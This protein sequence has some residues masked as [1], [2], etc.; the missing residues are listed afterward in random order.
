MSNLKA[1]L[2][3]NIVLV[4]FTL[5]TAAIYGWDP[6]KVLLL[7]IQVFWVLVLPLNMSEADW[8]SKWYL[9]ERQIKKMKRTTCLGHK[10]GYSLY[11]DNCGFYHAISD[12]DGLTNLG[13]NPERA[14]Y[15]WARLKPST[16]GEYDGM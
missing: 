9:P 11:K 6:I 2:L 10:Y 3:L 5:A 7:I 1:C 8:D 12:S 16:K 15:L 13:D 14:M 4:I